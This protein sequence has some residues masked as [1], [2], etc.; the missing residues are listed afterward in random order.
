MN[1][2]QQGAV[3]GMSERQLVP[4]FG[5]AVMLCTLA[6]SAAAALLVGSTYG[7]SGL[8]A[9]VATI[10]LAAGVL[11]FSLKR[12]SYGSQVVLVLA[13]AAMVAL[14]IQLGR[15]TIEFHFGVFVLLGL[16]LVYRDWR[17]VVLTAGFFAVHHVAFDRLQAMGWR[18]YCTPQP[19]LLKTSMHAIYVVVQAAVELVLAT[20]LR[21]AT[22]TSSELA[23]LIERIDAGDSVCLDVADI[24][25]KSP[26]AIL[27]K[28]AVGKVHAAMQDVSSAAASIETAATEISTGNSDLSMRTEEQASNLQRTAS[29]MEEI[30]GTVRNLASSADRADHLARQASAA[31]SAGGTA[32]AKVV[33]TIDEIASSSRRI[34]DIIGT[35]DGIAFQ[36]N[37]LALNAAVEAARAG[38]QG[39]GFAV[40]AGEVRALAKRSADASKE[41]RHL[42]A[43]STEKVATGTQLVAAAGADMQ[44]IV[45]QAESVSQLIGQISGAAREQTLGISDVG[46]AVAQL[47]GVT[48]QNAALV[49]QSAAA[50]DSLRN[51]TVLLNTVVG[52]F[53]LERS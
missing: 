52:R 1:L 8:A 25:V 53:C 37:I 42:I 11:A 22:R 46:D 39:R 38:D 2:T 27:L 45:D 31:A 47:D 35:I 24:Q 3:G 28:G 40:V 41:I 49:E 20:A 13:N 12:G 44:S 32:V 4:R 17:A 23:M 29:S 6:A 7:S 50:A 9:V 33:E 34:E 19:D 18:V 36:T 51:Q 16:V 5:D 30:T 14:H 21:R 48:Q 26:I 10:L 43:T 15:G